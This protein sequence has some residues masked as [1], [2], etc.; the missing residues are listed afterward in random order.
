MNP[1]TRG[2]ISAAAPIH[3]LAASSPAIDKMYSRFG[4]TPRICFDF[5]KMQSLLDWHEDKFE[6]ALSNLSSRTLQEMVNGARSLKFDDVSH[7]IVLMKRRGNDLSRALIIVEP[8]TLVVEMA[9]RNQLKKETQ[10]ERLALYRSLAN[11]E[12]ARRLAGVVYESL[13][14][15]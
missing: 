10:A 12:A 3:G 1:W 5:P 7:T 2:E 15:E 8:I 4:P 6:S 11:V 9:L 13:A 14:Q